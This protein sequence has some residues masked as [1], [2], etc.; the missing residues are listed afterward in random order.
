MEII[1]G[2]SES[3]MMLEALAVIKNPQATTDEKELAWEDFEMLIQQIDNASST[4]FAAS[5]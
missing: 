2:K 4:L 3:K 5:Q 1:L